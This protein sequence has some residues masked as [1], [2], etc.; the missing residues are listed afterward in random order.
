MTIY[1][2]C[3][4]DRGFGVVLIK[5]F[6]SLKEAEQFCESFGGDYIEKVELE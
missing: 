2:A 4:E 1:V 5:A 3:E 6:Y